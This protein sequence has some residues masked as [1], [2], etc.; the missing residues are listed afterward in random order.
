M[1]AFGGL[2]FVLAVLA[3][4]WLAARNLR[5]ALRNPRSRHGTQ[6]ALIG[7]LIGWLLAG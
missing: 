6:G 5:D 7:A 4:L 1:D 2:L 3:G